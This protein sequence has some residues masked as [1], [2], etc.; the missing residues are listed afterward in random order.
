MSILIINRHESGKDI[1]IKAGGEKCPCGK[2]LFKRVARCNE[3][4][5]G[6]NLHY[7]ICT[8]CGFETYAHNKMAVKVERYNKWKVKK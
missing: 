7:D 4:T 8:N 5:D 2:G 1:P 3:S 6:M